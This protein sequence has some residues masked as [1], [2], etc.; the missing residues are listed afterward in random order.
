MKWNK[1]GIQIS[2]MQENIGIGIEAKIMELRITD[3]T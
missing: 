3:T 2:Y 1:N